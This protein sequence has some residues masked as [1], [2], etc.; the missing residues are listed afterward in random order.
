[1]GNVFHGLTSATSK[2]ITG[3]LKNLAIINAADRLMRNPDLS[4]SELR[5]R[6][7][8]AADSID[9]FF[10]TERLASRSKILN[11][12]KAVVDLVMPFIHYQTAQLRGTAAGTIAVA[13]GNFDPLIRET[14]GAILTYA[15]LSASAQ[16]VMTKI[17]TGHVIYPT[18]LYDLVR[19]RTGKKN[20][21]GSDERWSPPGNPKP[22]IDQAIRIVHG[23]W[24]KLIGQVT[25][26]IFTAAA[27]AIN[28]RNPTTG[29]AESPWERAKSIG[30]MFMFGPQ[31]LSQGDY[32]KAIT[33]TVFGGESPG[34]EERSEAQ[35][36]LH[37]KLLENSEGNQSPA[38]RD[39]WAKWNA[40]AS[41]PDDYDANRDEI[42]QEMRDSGLVS[43]E[44]IK[45]ADKRWSTP[46]GIG[47]EMLNKDLTP[48]DMLDA[49]NL[50]T[51]DEQSEMK[52]AIQ[53]RWRKTK[54][55]GMAASKR[56]AWDS[57]LD[58]VSD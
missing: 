42:Q 10:G 33:S 24:G 8:D 11:N 26:N 27:E 13:R 35:N 41:T 9:R 32:S 53:E 28:G 29:Q 43:D 57:L 1:M 55:K 40:K 22:A 45:L 34:D 7:Q 2:Y 58:A 6:A 5:M 47:K 38:E 17:N 44:Q 3:P 37:T 23:D 4:D 19:P 52:D 30:S 36:F 54:V 14:A 56:A 48:Q 18:R 46:N 20:A 21:D 31:G 12:H 16:I 49:Y 39:A 51:P 25:N 50:A 15:T